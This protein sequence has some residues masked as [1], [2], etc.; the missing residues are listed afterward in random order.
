MFLVVARSWEE[1]GMGNEAVLFNRHR[2][3][4]GDNERFFQE[5]RLW[6]WLDNIGRVINAT[7]L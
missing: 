2:V 3:S 4:V 7:K 5:N 6:R 1:G